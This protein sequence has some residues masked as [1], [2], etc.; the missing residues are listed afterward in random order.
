[1]ILVFTDCL[2]GYGERCDQSTPTLK[3]RNFILHC[4][5][6]CNPNLKTQFCKQIDCGSNLFLIYLFFPSV[7]C[8]IMRKYKQKLKVFGA[9]RL[10]CYKSGSLDNY[11]SFV[12]SWNNSDDFIY[13]DKLLLVA[14]R[15]GRRD[16]DIKYWYSKWISDCK[17][18]V[19]Q[20]KFPWPVFLI[21][22]F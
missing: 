12:C 10:P 3:T 11:K 18:I 4:N 7:S 17:L 5:I 16:S 13:E 9:G 19:L 8:L 22:C 1:M 6:V 14:F 20:C 2:V 15:F 21:I